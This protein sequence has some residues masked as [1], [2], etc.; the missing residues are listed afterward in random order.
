MFIHPQQAP[1]AGRRP[2][3][4]FPYHAAFVYAA[5]QFAVCFRGD[6]RMTQDPARVVL[7]DPDTVIFICFQTGR[8]FIVTRINQRY[9]Y[10]RF[11]RHFIQ[12]LPVYPR[13]FHRRTGN[14]FPF[15]LLHRFLQVLWG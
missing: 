9:P 8:I 5:E 1:D 14:A 13:G 3:F 7:M 6:V 4:L 11:F 12:A 10:V 2:A 15:Q